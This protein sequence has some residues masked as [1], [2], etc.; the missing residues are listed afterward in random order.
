MSKF[1]EGQVKPQSAIQ[2]HV[3]YL[4]A[5]HSPATSRL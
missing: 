2:V 3:T 4:T 1:R 5:G